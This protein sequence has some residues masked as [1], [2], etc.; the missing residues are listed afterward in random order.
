MDNSNKRDLTTMDRYD[1]ERQMAVVKLLI[2]N[3]DFRGRVIGSIDQNSLTANEYLRHICAYVKELEG[4][5]VEPSYSNIN[6]HIKSSVADGIRC[7]GMISTLQRIKCIPMTPDEVEYFKNDV[8]DILH[9]QEA[10][11]LYGELGELIRKN[12][13]KLDRDEIISYF[14]DYERKTSFTSLGYVDA[15]MTREEVESLFSERA[16]EYI[17]TSSKVIDSILGGGLRKGDVG[18]FLAGSGVAKTCMTTSFVCAAAWRGNKVAH[19]V[20]EDKKDDIQRKYVSFITGIPSNQIDRVGAQSKEILDRHY[21]NLS[22]MLA[23][24]KGVFCTERNGRIR[25]MKIS[26]IDRELNRMCRNGFHPDMVVID[27]FDRL[28]RGNDKVWVRDERAINDLLDLA[29][30]YNVAIWCPTQGGKDAQNPNVELELDKASGGVWKTYGAQVVIS[31]KR[32]EA[33]GPNAFKV[34]TL[35]NRYARPYV[36]RLTNFNNGT[37]RFEDEDAIMGRYEETEEAVDSFQDRMAHKAANN[38]TKNRQ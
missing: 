7:A 38:Y 5:G 15:S 33:D 29:T 25:K 19:I 17:K 21:G 27:Y 31:A 8:C 32:S 30:K 6:L 16:Y 2:E 28:D 22:K 14:N 24:V 36:E 3:A 4:K 1:E 10:R 9:Y 18:L 13:A 12:S 23:N 34:K 26:D 20:L 37:C 11:K 35:K